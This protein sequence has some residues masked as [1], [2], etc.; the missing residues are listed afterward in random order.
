[1]GGGWSQTVAG[2]PGVQHSMALAVK[3]SIPW[4]QA[5]EPLDLNAALV[6]EDG[7]AVD[8]GQG[9]I[10]AT[11]N[12]EVGRPPGL[13]RGTPLDSVLALNFAGLELRPGGYVWQLSINGETKARTPFRVLSQG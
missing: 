3:L 1:L 12:L 9:P 7:Q 4:D 2:S 8:L 13:R 10:A 5:N 6:T 11:G